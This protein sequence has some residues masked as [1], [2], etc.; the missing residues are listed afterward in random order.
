MKHCVIRRFTGVWW[1]SAKGVCCVVGEL[2]DG[3]LWCV[4][5]HALRFFVRFEIVTC[6]GCVLMAVGCLFFEALVACNMLETM[7]GCLKFRVSCIGV[8]SNGRCCRKLCK[9]VC[10]LEEMGVDWGLCLL[11][12]FVSDC[13]YVEEV[14]W[15]C[16]RK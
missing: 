9:R 6:M 2:I 1:E 13:R 11:S 12:L 3:R 14:D 7:S 16:E 4:L 10:H 15:S 5:C 8:G